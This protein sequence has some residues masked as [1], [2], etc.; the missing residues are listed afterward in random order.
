MNKESLIRKFNKQAAIYERNTRQRRLGEWR[1]RLLQD[2]EG[3]V[4]EVAVGAGANFPF[5]Q[6]DKVNVTAVDFS[7]EMLNRAR[8]MASELGI[9]ANFLERDIETLELPERS[10]D[11]VVST[12]SLC[13]YEDPVKALNKINRWAKPGGRVYLLEHGMST[14]RFLGAMQHL[15]NPAGRRISGCHFNRDMIHIANASEL[16]IVKTERYWNG[17]V[18]LIWA[19][20]T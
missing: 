20:A 11:C 15:I 7:P 17:I 19:Q 1:Q 10:Y 3:N 8:R 2:V 18:H 12:L 6:R 13:G 9:R 16:N 14:N 5:Y 4:L